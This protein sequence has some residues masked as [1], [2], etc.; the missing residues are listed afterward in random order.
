MDVESVDAAPRPAKEPM[1]GSFPEKDDFCLTV[2]NLGERSKTLFPAE[3]VV[4]PSRGRIF[5][6]A[7]AAS[8]F[9]LA[10]PHAGQ[11]FACE[12][13]SAAPA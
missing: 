13:L 2:A 1:P 4:F 8:S 12:L 3:P 10:L 5:N 7:G 9:P 11:A 6:L